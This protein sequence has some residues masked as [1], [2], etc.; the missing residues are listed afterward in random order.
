MRSLTTEAIQLAMYNTKTW[1]LVLINNR[2]IV[3]VAS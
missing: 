2:L 3:T 1:K